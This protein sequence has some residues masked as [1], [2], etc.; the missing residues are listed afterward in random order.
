V[1]QPPESARPVPDGLAPFWD[2]QVS[3]FATLP[4]EPIAPEMQE[5]HRIYALC[6]MGLLA[7]YWN[8]NKF[9]ETGDYGAWRTSQVVAPLPSGGNLY[10]GGTYLG[11]NIAAIAV[12]GDGRVM[13]YEF[14]H[15]N[16]FDSSVEHAESRLVRRLF[17]LS[18]VYS[19]WEQDGA[20]GTA[21]GAG[22]PASGA[23]VA[24]P[25]ASLFATSSTAPINRQYS[26]L[27]DNV[28]I[29][30]SLESCAQCSGIM[31][32]ASVANIVYLEWDQGEFLIGN[33]MYRA[34]QAAPT[35]F[36]APRPIGGDEIGLTY[37]DQLNQ[38]NDSFG[39]AVATS[40]FYR[41]TG[42]ASTTPSVTSYLCTD[43]ARA[44]YEAGA[45]DFASL[46]GRLAFGAWSPPGSGGQ[47]TNAQ[48]CTN[49]QAFLAYAQAVGN[50]GTPHRV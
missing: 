18:Q 6:L 11:H 17:A 15:N 21:P 39:T 43:G 22:A 8:G 38:G 16:V 45:A 20:P 25:A 41:S 4:P 48:A 31:T 32:L 27:L 46:A 9:G 24:A 36:D 29:Y 42:F 28:T 19:P 30:T 3:A 37:F 7:T 12:D 23:A 14:N 2:G 33:L 5:R 49:A 50:R 34:T 26:T 44:I 10:A 47:L 1:G 40:P 35:G 13:D